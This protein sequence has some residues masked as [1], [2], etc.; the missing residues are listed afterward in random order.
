MNQAN[1]TRLTKLYGI[2]T[3]KYMVNIP[4][5]YC[6]C[7]Q[8]RAYDQQGHEDRRRPLLRAFGFFRE[9]GGWNDNFR[10]PVKRTD[11]LSGGGLDYPKTMS[12][13]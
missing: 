8:S 6:S 12:E 9:D 2:L 5:T 1:E 7:G 3:M 4:L 10:G 11:W 13:F